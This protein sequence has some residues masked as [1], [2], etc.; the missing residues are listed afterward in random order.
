MTVLSNDN[1][2]GARG[3]CLDPHDLVVSKLVAGRMKDLE[4]ADV[5]LRAGL[6]DPDVLIRRAAD[7]SLP[8]H[9]NRVSGW[10]IGWTAKHGRH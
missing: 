3:H 2:A 8:A 7:L 5:L 4:F 10:V 9:R 1:T 6:I